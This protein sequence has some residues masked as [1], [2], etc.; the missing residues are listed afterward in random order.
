MNRKAIIYV[1]TLGLF[2]AL[3]WLILE[4]GKGLHASVP[5]VAAQQSVT[6]TNVAGA[7]KVEG[8]FADVVNNL[9]HPVS[10]LFLQIISILIVSR[11]FGYI[12]QK[13]GQPSVIGEIFAGIFLGP[14]LFGMLFPQV[15]AFLFPV[16]SLKT[17][18]F[19]SQVGLVFFMFIIGMELDVAI[20]KKRAQDALVVSHASIVFPY[21]LGMCLAFFMYERYAPANISFLS[22][23]LFMGI[24]MSI[25]AFPVLARIMQERGITKTPLGALALTCAA[26]DDIT[27]W[28]I[29][30][31][32]IAIA[33]A[34]S[35][36][37]VLVTIG[38]SV[39]YVGIMLYAVR[40]LLSRLCITYGNK[41]KTDKAIIALVFVV[42]LGSAYIAELI[43]IH[44]LFGAFMAGVIMPAD[45][46]FKH[47]VT[48]KVED[49]SLL[50]FLPIFFV[51]TGLR[52]QI[53]L[54]NQPSLWGVCTIVV[55]VAIL[56]KF[57][58]SAIAARLVGRSW[59]DALGIGALMN[60]R[61][62]MEL[63]ALNIG[64]DLGILT[65][66]IFAIMV[67][68]A[69]VTTLMT[70]PLLTAIGAMKE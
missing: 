70:G 62:L 4:K 52:T 53:G 14:S 39:V 36:S 58:G 57:G 28:C 44:V 34:G 21:F 16:D 55:F 19:F 43:G 12:A 24:A 49:V 11:L 15:S 42:L 17:L 7:V 18:Q 22:F 54:L 9:H 64:Y 47:S 40:P 5:P 30:P 32:V 25:T 45:F 37:G 6:V 48:G 63:I 20:L 65:P 59:K 61:G 33:K 66:E 27:A 41:Q 50:L 3:M 1:V 38:L 51:F 35:A 13:V 67:I 29:L 56:G 26:A 68:M 23:A 46:N 69:L 8:I 60:T 10:V 2:A 31:V